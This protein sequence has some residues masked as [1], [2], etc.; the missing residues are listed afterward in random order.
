MH[1]ISKVVQKGK[2]PEQYQKECREMRRMEQENYVEKA[3]Q[4]VRLKE[5]GWDDTR[6]ILRLLF[7]Y[8][9]DRPFS[10]DAFQSDLKGLEKKR[11]RIAEGVEP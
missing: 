3:E 1:V 2:P 7:S 9:P 8:T 4:E 6:E 10:C 5:V 11:E